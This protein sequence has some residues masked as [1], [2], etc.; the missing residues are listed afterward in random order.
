MDMPSPPLP[1]R[2]FRTTGSPSSRTIRPASVSRPERTRG[3]PSPTSR[4]LSD[5]SSLSVPAARWFHASV[6]RLGGSKV[7]ALPAATAM[8]SVVCT[9]MMCSPSRI[10]GR[11]MGSED[12][13]SQVERPV[14]EQAGS[15]A[16]LA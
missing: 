13:P 6:R 7:N 3:T 2:S 16:A 8:A 4:N 15:G 11:S 5:T 10:P 12:I 1:T 9:S 14:E